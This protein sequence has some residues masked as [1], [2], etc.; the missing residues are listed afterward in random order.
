M[1]AVKVLQ[2]K[3]RAPWPGDSQ[4]DGTAF[5]RTWRSPHGSAMQDNSP[6]KFSRIQSKKAS[7][8]PKK[9]L[10]EPKPTWDVLPREVQ[11]D[12]GNWHK[13]FGETTESLVD[14]Q[15]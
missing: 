7:M 2:N 15:D 14:G 1:E 11:V 6:P 12:V 9:L 5:L 3:R 4:Q 8:A 10:K 13:K